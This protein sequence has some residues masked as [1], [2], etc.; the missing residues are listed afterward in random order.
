MSAVHKYR[1]L[2]ELAELFT[3]AD[4][5]KEEIEKAG[6]QAIATLYGCKHGSD[7]NLERA[8]KFNEKVAS[9]SSYLPPER[10]PPTSD[11]ARFHSQHVYLQVQ[12]WLGNNLEATEWGWVICKTRCESV[13]RPHRMDQPAAP[14][15]LLTI[16]KC[17]CTGMCAKNTCSCRKKMDSS[18]PWRVVSARHNMNKWSKS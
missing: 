13:L 15:S 4:A 8:S 9:S 6:I 14:A 17:K 1:D 2:K 5:N 18:V 12:A 16:I 10:L 11:A 3:S 7:L